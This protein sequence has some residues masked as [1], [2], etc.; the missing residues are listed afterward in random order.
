[1]AECCVAMTTYNFSSEAVFADM[2]FKVLC[3]RAAIRSPRTEAAEHQGPNSGRT[4]MMAVTK[5]F[6]LKKKYQKQKP[7]KKDSRPS[8]GSQRKD[9]ASSKAWLLNWE[10]KSKFVLLCLVGCGWFYEELHLSLLCYQWLHRST[11][12]SSNPRFFNGITGI[13]L[14]CCFS[15]F[16]ILCLYLAYLEKKNVFS[17]LV[18]RLRSVLSSFVPLIEKFRPTGNWSYCLHT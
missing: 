9:G 5:D 11:Y 17:Q 8:L 7:Q 6:I 18:Y 4:W 12:L 2:F 14:T 16:C 3:T 10:Q 15:V 13:C 1:M